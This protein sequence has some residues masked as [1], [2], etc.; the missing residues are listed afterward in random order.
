MKFFKPRFE[1][2]PNHHSDIFKKDTILPY[3]KE[4]CE[5]EKL[6]HEMEKLLEDKCLL[7][8]SQIEEMQRLS[9]KVNRAE[10][11]VKEVQNILYIAGKEIKKLQEDKEVFSIERS[12]IWNGWVKIM[13]KGE[14]ILK[15]VQKEEENKEEENETMSH[16]VISDEKQQKGKESEG[17][18]D[19]FA[20]LPTPITH[21]PTKKNTPFSSREKA[22]NWRELLKNGGVS[23]LVQKHGKKGGKKECVTVTSKDRVKV[24]EFNGK[25]YIGIPLLLS[26]H[27]QKRIL[28]LTHRRYLRCFLCHKYLTPDRLP[29]LRQHCNGDKHVERR[30]LSTCK[31]KKTQLL[32]K[33]IPMC[34][35]T[36]G[37]S[38]TTFQTHLIRANL[39]AM[40]AKVGFGIRGFDRAWEELSIITETSRTNSTNLHRYLD[41]LGE[42]EL[43]NTKC[44]LQQCSED[45]TLI[46]DST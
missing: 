45:F 4:K 9:D 23:G 11:E 37:N 10:K 24:F 12:N 8:T 14:E 38:R 20:S 22:L 13:K 34:F 40:S 33:I 28:I 15:H 2:H 17:N 3:E 32:Q 29:N 31:N 41:V 46:T 26:L 30:K 5:L 6:R 7:P 16:D 35:N 1:H 27:T 39:V 44:F 36:S 25:W 21:P 42:R 19:S 18:S 43:R